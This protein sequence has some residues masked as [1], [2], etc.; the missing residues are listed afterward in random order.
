MLREHPERGSVFFQRAPDHRG[1][2][3]QSS[4]G[5][6]PEVAHAQLLCSKKAL[7]GIWG[8]G[9]FRLVQEYANHQHV[10]LAVNG[11]RENVVIKTRSKRSVTVAEEVE[12]IYQEFNFL[13]HP[14]PPHTSSAVQAC[15]TAS[16][17]CTWC[18]S[19]AAT[20]AW[21]R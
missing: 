17:I 16:P 21:S 20:S 19:M 18:S 4:L 10:L 14:R 2:T 1:R 5:D 12:S 3:R 15:C 6:H 11:Q 7:A 13:T 8:Q 9:E